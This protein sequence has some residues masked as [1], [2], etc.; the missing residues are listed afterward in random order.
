MVLREMKTTPTFRIY[1]NGVQQAALEATFSADGW[2]IPLFR[3]DF[4]PFTS[5]IVEHSR[6]LLQVTESRRHSVVQ[7]QEKCWPV[8]VIVNHENRPAHVSKYSISPFKEKLAHPL[9]EIQLSL[10]RGC[11]QQFRVKS[12]DRRQKMS[13]LSRLLTPEERFSEVTNPLLI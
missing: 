9:G 3:A 8:R 12:K 13:K 10:T 2:S 11:E 6:Y 4:L 5:K 1:R 7:F